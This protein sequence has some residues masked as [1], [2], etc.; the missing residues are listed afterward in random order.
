MKKSTTKKFPYP[1]IL[2]AILIILVTAYVIDVYAS[3]Y[4]ILNGSSDEYQ[5]IVDINTENT[6]SLINVN[7]STLI[8]FIESDTTDEHEYEYY[9]FICIDFSLA[10]LHNASLQNIS[11]G[12]AILDYHT[13]DGHAI[14]CFDTTDEGVVFIEPQTDSDIT[15]LIKILGSYSDKTIY[16]IHTFWN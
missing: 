16:A 10:L 5:E 11:S 6:E 12:I 8:S 3:K 1:Q 15:N 13:W 14:T 7:Y 9:S 4:I 2:V